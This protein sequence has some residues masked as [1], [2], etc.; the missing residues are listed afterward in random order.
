LFK[1]PKELAEEHWETYVKIIIGLHD[2]DEEMIRKIGVHYNLAFIHGYKHCARVI[3]VIRDFV[4]N[5]R[6]YIE[7]DIED[8]GM[9]KPILPYFLKEDES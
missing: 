7:K 1:T 2:D 8:F 9:L 3:E 5:R 6:D 4:L